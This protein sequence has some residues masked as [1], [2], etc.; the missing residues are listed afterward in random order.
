MSI[1]EIITA[2]AAKGW[3]LEKVHNRPGGQ[4]IF[5]SEAYGDERLAFNSCGWVRRMAS[6]AN[7]YTFQ[8]SWY[9]IY[10]KPFA[11]LEQAGEALLHYVERN[12]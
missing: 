5:K 6:T 1:N 10:R 7:I 2:L 12:K 11:S 4:W 9:Q 3:E 8:R